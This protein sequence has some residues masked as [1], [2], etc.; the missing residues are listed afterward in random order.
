MEYD[1]SS[2][3][4]WTALR[5]KST[6]VIAVLLKAEFW[7]LLFVH[8]AVSISYKTGVFTPK[9][10][11]LDLPMGLTSVTGGLMTFFVVFYNGNV[12]ARYNRLYEL[13]KNMNE[14]CLYAVSI[15]SREVPDKT[16][17]RKLTRQLL[18]SSFLFF[19]ER[20]E[21]SGEAEHNVSGDEWDQLQGM[22]LLN[23]Y[24]MMLLKA[25]CDKLGEH[26]CPSFLLVQ[27]S[28]RLYRTK[29]ARLNELEKTY[30]NIRR[31]QDDVVEI[32]ELPMPFQYFHIM[33]LMLMLNLTLW[34]YS[35]ALEDSYFSSL[36]FMFVQLVFQGV[37]ELSVALADP[38]GDDDADFPVNEWMTT[39]YQRL[40]SIVE[41]PWDLQKVV[42]LP[43][44]GPME[45]LKEGQ[46][47]INLL[48]DHKS[49]GK[50]KAKKAAKAKPKQKAP[51]QSKL[52]A[53]GRQVYSKLPQEDP[54]DKESGAES[55]GS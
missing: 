44:V 2:G 14:Y 54:E 48:I 13:T 18:A 32:M 29:S 20:T 50:A 39:L 37:R 34:A 5:L 12:F 47:I 40:Y 19:F 10:Y 42:P 6:V 1:P 36:I 23:E 26:A 11:K 16:L 33:N 35:L 17:V 31:C 8:L 15:I 30:W 46:D 4:L 28:M 53:D 22:D 45:K 25:H 27:W 52:D 51:R 49:G 7:L 41:D 43:D 3:I 38:Y 9:D 55:E 21:H 24:E